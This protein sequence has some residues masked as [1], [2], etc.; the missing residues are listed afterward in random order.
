MANQTKTSTVTDPSVI[1]DRVLL[2][3][4]VDFKWLMAGHGWWIDTSRLHCDSG[5]ATELL[6]LAGTTQSPTLRACAHLLQKQVSMRCD[7]NLACV[8]LA[9]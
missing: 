1:D 2:L 3:E 5:Y 9:G 8:E 7:R 6:K 4:E